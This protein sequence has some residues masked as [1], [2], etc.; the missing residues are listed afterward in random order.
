MLK[1]TLI[2]DLYRHSNIYLF[3]VRIADV[4]FIINA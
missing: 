2:W 1:F 3:L 4:Y